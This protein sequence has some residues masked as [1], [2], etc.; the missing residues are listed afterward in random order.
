MSFSGFGNAIVE[1]WLWNINNDPKC[2]TTTD[3]Y[4]FGGWITYWYNVFRGRCMR[5]E[6]YAKEVPRWVRD[7]V[8]CRKQELLKER[9]PGKGSSRGEYSEETF[10][11]CRLDQAQVEAIVDGLYK[12]RE[13]AHEAD[14]A[15]Y[16][17]AE[18][19]AG[20]NPIHAT[21]KLRMTSPPESGFSDTDRI[22]ERYI[23]ELLLEPLSRPQMQEALTSYYGWEKWTDDPWGEPQKFYS[24]LS[25]ITDDDDTRAIWTI[26]ETL[27]GRA[28]LAYGTVFALDQLDYS[29][30]TEENLLDYIGI[31]AENF[32]RVKSY[33]DWEDFLNH[34]PT[35]PLPS[36]LVNKEIIK[37]WPFWSFN[38]YRCFV[39]SIYLWLLALAEAKERAK[40][41]PVLEGLLSYH[42]IPSTHIA[43]LCQK[44]AP[45]GYQRLDKT[46]AWQRIEQQLK[47]GLEAKTAKYDDIY[48]LRSKHHD[49]LKESYVEA[50]EKLLEVLE[51][52]KPVP[53]QDI[54]KL[55]FPLSE[56]DIA[57]IRGESAGINK[58]YDAAIK[59]LRGQLGNSLLRAVE[60]D[61][62]DDTRKS[63]RKHEVT[64][65]QIDANRRRD[66]ED[67]TPFFDTIASPEPT[68]QQLTE[69]KE[70]IDLKNLVLNIDELKPAELSLLNEFCDATDKDIP[71]TK[72]WGKD[73][74]KKIK[75]L[76]RL[77]P[78]LI[79]A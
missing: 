17:Q 39:A 28:F 59:G 35:E 34:Y 8:S 50:H 44:L 77:R 27:A 38:A 19:E 71:L 65:S 13:E 75:R 69:S 15:V 21:G 11:L 40:G 45:K 55:L 76:S 78:K 43:E 24:W 9:Y 23:R 41:H 64:E 5:R 18:G 31:G 14:L 79:K 73:Y 67:T 29:K 66:E 72:Y 7:F 32:L 12:L 6:R 54:S 10:S 74:T 2:R 37:G 3:L 20:K 61:F 30:M 70:P 62:V 48:S 25:N 51:D 4:S 22:S 33:T 42:A 68:P 53:H 26:N 47:R 58:L 63:Y 52:L 56:D 60:N 57:K 16:L 1:R 46:Q 49:T 36:R